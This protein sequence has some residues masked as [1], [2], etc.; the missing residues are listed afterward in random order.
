VAVPYRIGDSAIGVATV[1]LDEL[2]AALEC[3]SN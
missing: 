2:V 3:V 1:A